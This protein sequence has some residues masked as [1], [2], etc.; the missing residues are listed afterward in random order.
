MLKVVKR[1]YSKD[2]K[3]LMIENFTRWHSIVLRD[4]KY[5]VRVAS[6]KSKE[7]TL[8]SQVLMCFLAWRRLY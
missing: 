3:N 6:L 5:A 1:I 4:K 2:R 8:P 7:K